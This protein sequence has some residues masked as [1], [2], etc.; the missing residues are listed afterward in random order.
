MLF[1]SA[2]LAIIMM[3]GIV[4][5][6]L[7]Y[8]YGNIALT[9]QESLHWLSLKLLYPAVYLLGAGIFVGSV[10]ANLSWGRY[11]G[12]D[13][14]EV[15]ALITLLIYSFALHSDSIKSFRKP[16]FFHAFNVISFLCVL[17]TF[18]G[19]NYFLGGLHSYA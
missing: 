2:L 12:W 6:F 18:L 4:G 9:K 15:W 19:V 13:P 8:R 5:L 3:N 17:M 14:K 1:R 10:W 16:V 7:N 11:W